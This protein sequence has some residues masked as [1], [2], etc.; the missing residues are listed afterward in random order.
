MYAP[1]FAVTE[2]V[3]HSRL[4]FMRRRT[5]YAACA[6]A[7]HKVVRTSI[8]ARYQRYRTSEYEAS[9]IKTFRFLFDAAFAYAADA[10]SRCTRRSHRYD[11]R[12]SRTQQ[13]LSAARFFALTPSPISAFLHVSVCRHITPEQVCT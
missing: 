2:A 4:M 10:A 8:A 11:L 3:T 12:R 9:L 1:R 6:A 5:R 13:M 7:R